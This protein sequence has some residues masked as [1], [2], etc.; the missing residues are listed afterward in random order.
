MLQVPKKLAVVMEE[1]KVGNFVML[2]AMF[3][4]GKQA[5]K[6]IIDRS[7]VILVLYEQVSEERKTKTHHISADIN[8]I[9]IVLLRWDHPDVWLYSL[10]LY[11]G[12]R[13]CKR[14]FLR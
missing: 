8:N 11:S 2:L 1:A 13:K 3:P 4:I 12:W 7:K 10:T 9:V 6:T 14:D 5:I